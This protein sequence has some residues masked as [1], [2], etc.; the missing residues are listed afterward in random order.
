MR[1]TNSRVIRVVRSGQEICSEG[2]A[3]NVH[4]CND[5]I[6]HMYNFFFQTVFSFRSVSHFFIIMLQ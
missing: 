5:R 2:G 3:N 4:D 1:K 6:L